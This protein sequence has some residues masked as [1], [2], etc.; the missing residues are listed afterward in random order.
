MKYN[1]QAHLIDKLVISRVAPSACKRASAV[2]LMVFDVDGV[3]TDGSLYYGAEGELIKRFN[4]HDGL[5]MRFLARSGIKIALM[6]SRYSKILNCRAS[7]L[8][9]ATVMQNVDN[10]GT[11]LSTLS[12]NIKVPLDRIG[13]MGDDIVDLPALEKAVFSAGVFNAPSYV[14]QA[15]HWVSKRLGGNG[16]VRECCEL[17][18]ASQGCLGTIV[19]SF[20]K[21]YF[22]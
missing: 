11:A 6:T 20:K 17:I 9:I 10:K 8:G 14:L 18:L 15:T 16:A 19:T 7:E 13:Y 5:G 22:E 12:K 3:L 4:A 2:R 1:D 21:K